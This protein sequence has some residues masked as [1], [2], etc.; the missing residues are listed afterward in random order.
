MSVSVSA[1]TGP[2]AV[3]QSTT[4]SDNDGTPSPPLPPQQPPPPELPEAV[5]ELGEQVWAASTRGRESRGGG[6]VSQ[7]WRDQTAAS[8]LLC[9]VTDATKANPDSLELWVLLC[10]VT[11]LF[12]REFLSGE[13]ILTRAQVRQSRGTHTCTHTRTHSL[14][15]SPCKHTFFITHICFFCILCNINAGLRGWGSVPLSHHLPLASHV[16]NLVAKR[17]LLRKHTVHVCNHSNWLWQTFAVVLLQHV[18]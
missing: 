5:R 11:D 3:P 2:R 7:V 17:N 18:C 10:A 12:E 13:N 9:A 4:T 6:S 16:L 1:S 15:I 14:F 8:D